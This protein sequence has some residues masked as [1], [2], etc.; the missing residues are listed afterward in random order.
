M[1]C[2]AV[3]DLTDGDDDSVIAC[4]TVRDGIDDTVSDR[5]PVGCMVDVGVAACVAVLVCVAVAVSRSVSL[6]VVVA[7]REGVLDAVGE[8]V[9]VGGG[10]IVTVAD[11]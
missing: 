10:V 9:G 7:E 6:R 5:L 11:S 2:G 1:V 4:D 8:R 3:I